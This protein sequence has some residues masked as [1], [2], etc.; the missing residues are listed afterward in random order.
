[1][2]FL[3]KGKFTKSHIVL[4]LLPLV[5]GLAGLLYI[6]NM[7]KNDEKLL[8]VKQ[9]QAYEL[10]GYLIAEKIQGTLNSVDLLLLLLQN[11]AQAVNFN[12]SNEGREF[13]KYINT[14][15]RFF[16]HLDNITLFNSKGELLFTED[17]TRSKHALQLFSS[18]KRNHLEKQLPFY[19][20]KSN[21]NNNDEIV[22][23][24]MDY[25]YETGENLIFVGELCKDS[26]MTNFDIN[27]SLIIDEA[28]VFDRNGEIF[29]SLE[30]REYKDLYSL[31][32]LPL[33]E[34]KSLGGEGLLGGT[35]NTILN[36]K[37]VTIIQLEEFSLFL[38]IKSDV[39]REFN[40][41][42][43]RKTLAIALILLGSF[44]VFII[45]FIVNLHELDK[46]NVK[47]KAYSKLEMLVD[48]RTRELQAA[49]EENIKL[50]ATDGLT[51]LLNRRSMTTMITES[52]KH[53]ERYKDVFSLVMCDID[54]F[55]RINDTLGHEM[56][57]EALKFIVNCLKLNFRDSD[58][59]ARWG[60]EE[61]III[62]YKTDNQQA[63]NITEKIRVLIEKNPW[64]EDF[65]L[66]CS[67]GVTTYIEGDNIH[68]IVKRT[69]VALYRAKVTRNRVEI[70]A[71]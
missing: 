6:L 68:T 31:L 21:F 23:S 2:I 30:N 52:I 65:K 66:T 46:I 16:T 58:I 55:K 24:R 56:G 4:M 32:G 19:L 69:D 42:N 67:F 60:G 51:G 38:G 15:A 28:V 29:F 47:Q 11:K 9:I 57:D 45:I 10:S 13:Y 34:I 20:F 17:I 48:L 54:H 37:I 5:V 41:L 49:V 18:L 62:L 61:F 26:L 27:N 70:N 63:F 33:A 50:A 3:K 22:I 35:N 12:N 8:L 36:N 44:L 39:G 53:S 40:D 25:N 64:R 71:I 1:M 14:R 59:V 43:S 7:F